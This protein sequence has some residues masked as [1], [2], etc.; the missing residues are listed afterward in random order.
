MRNVIFIAIG[1]SLLLPAALFAE[2]DPA[3]H[4][5]A[6]RK[7][8]ASR[9][10]T[11]AVAAYDKILELDEEYKDAFDRWDACIKLAE[12]Q[13]GL[14]G[15]P[16]PMDLVRLGE[17]Y[18]EILAARKEAGEEPTKEREQELVASERACYTDAIAKD[19]GCTEAHGH[20]ALSNYV[21]RNGSI[22]TVIAE[23][24]R[25]LE[26]SPHRARLAEAIEHFK[27][28]GELRR[29]SSVLGD[30]YAAAR[31]AGQKKEFAKA[32]SILEEAATKKKDLPDAYY[33]WLW[34][35]IGRY[36]MQ[37]GDL[38]AARKAFTQSLGHVSHASTI[39]S[40]L[41]LASLDV[42]AGDLSAA[43]EHLKAAVAEGSSACVSIARRKASAFKALFEAEDT[44]I[45]EAAV[46]LTDQE[47]GDAPIRERIAKAVE[48]AN[49]EKKKVLVHWYG[50][51]CP[52]VMALEE[53]LARPEVREVLEKSF[54]HVK[55]DQGSGHRGG[56]L[57]KEYGGVMSKY[58]VP[59]FFVLD[60]EGEVEVVQR[61]LELMG[62]PHRD[63]DAEKVL[64]FLKRAAG[65]E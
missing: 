14:E 10:F 2:E 47:L 4:Y 43:L 6:A 40:R 30:E 3:K 34:S 65:V 44:A 9:D 15:E 38:E 25:F 28:Y 29:V 61:D 11:A 33:T 52:Y 49:K 17:V 24:F 22:S 57:D 23:T 5:E 50:P 60:A 45:R 53:R 64:A 21:G 54:V 7:A 12:W 27:V 48:Q 19:P 56:T 63:Y 1:I 36:R 35:W 59:C 46:K 37:S 20:L 62:T 32:A 58:G 42:K 41:G 18:V 51:Y 39:Q 16:K 8:E 13:E 55:M 26:T 31:R